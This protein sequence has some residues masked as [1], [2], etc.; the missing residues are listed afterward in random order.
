MFLDCDGRFNVHRL[1]Q[2]AVTYMLNAVAE[3][4]QGGFVERL[5]SQNPYAAEIEDLVTNAL[6]NVYVFQ[7]S[8]WMSL[9]ATVKSLETALS[10]PEY[11]YVPLG[12]ICIDSLSAFHHIVRSTDKSSEYYS[13]LSSSLRALSSLFGIFVIATSW[14]LSPLPT[15]QHPRRSRYID[16]GPSHP[17]AIT[18]HRT[19]WRQ[20][21][22]EGWLRGVD[23]RIVLHKK[24]VKAFLADMTL[25]EAEVEKEK[26][27]EAVKKGVV[28]G[29]V[30]SSEMGERTGEFE[31]FVT[32]EGVTIS[33]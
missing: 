24:D 5:A 17:H 18:S 23:R 6:F 22:P 32:D 1:R 21:F 4:T 33:P 9:L 26:R 2:I 31:M 11:A 29:W 28:L 30:E 16:L 19:L 3:N 8:S 27:T 25:K 10:Q 20:Y 15:E 14:A 13:Q 7:P 12:M